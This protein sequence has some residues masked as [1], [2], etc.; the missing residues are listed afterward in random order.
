M[1]VTCPNCGDEMVLDRRG[2]W[3]NRC[4]ACGYTEKR[5]ERG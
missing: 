2:K 4:P 1:G 3:K 5:N